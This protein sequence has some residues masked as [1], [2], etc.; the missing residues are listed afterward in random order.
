[1][2]AYLTD[3]FL[4]FLLNII[5]FPAS[6]YFRYFDLYLKTMSEKV[7]NKGFESRK[8]LKENNFGVLSTISLDVPGYPFG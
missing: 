4:N 7:I 3:I 5:Q 8:L 1:M 6:I 2:Q